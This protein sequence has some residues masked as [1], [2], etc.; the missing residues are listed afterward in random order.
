M[1]LEL[2]A[3]SRGVW[4]MTGTIVGNGSGARRLMFADITMTL[5][6]SM[7]PSLVAL[8][9]YASATNDLG[10]RRVPGSTSSQAETSSRDPPSTAGN[11]T[12]VPSAVAKRPK[13]TSGR[14][15]SATSFSGRTSRRFGRSDPAG[16]V[17]NRSGIVTPSRR[18]DPSTSTSTR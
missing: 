11:G 15:V 6:S 3:A 12:A 7:T 9:R 14:N 10:A 18:I 5:A 17:E 1:T 16:M 2:G 8:G 4:S 13:G